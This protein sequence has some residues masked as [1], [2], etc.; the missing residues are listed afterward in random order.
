[1]G[2]FVAFDRHMNLVLADSEEFRKLPKK[3]KTNDK[4][5]TGHVVNGSADMEKEDDSGLSTGQPFGFMNEEEGYCLMV[6]EESE[7]KEEKM[8][9]SPPMVSQTPVPIEVEVDMS[10]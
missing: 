1:M 2:R 9:D 8:D 6:H 5:G 4:S 3:K 7:E 10:M